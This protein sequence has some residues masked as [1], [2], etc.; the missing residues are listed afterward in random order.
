MTRRLIVVAVVV[1]IA[2]SACGK[3]ALPVSPE[4]RIPRPVTGLTAEVKQG[5]IEV[6]WTNPARRQD[7]TRLLDLVVARVYRNED[8]GT[9]QPKPALLSR[10]RILG[11]PELA[12]VNLVLTP[13]APGAPLPPTGPPPTEPVSWTI[14]GQ[15]VRL[16]DRKDLVYGRR[17]TYVVIVEDYNG[18]V[19]PPSTRASVVYLAAPAPPTGLT[20][21]VGEGQVRV[22]WTAP[23]ALADG[24]PLTAPPLYEVLR[25]T[26]PE[27]PLEVVTPAP[28]PA[29]R[30]IDQNVET[31]RVY[32]YAVRA[33]RRQGET[34]TA[35]EPSARVTAAPVATRAPA[36]PTNV[37]ATVAGTSV[38]LTWTA[39]PTPDLN[40]Y[41]VYRAPAGGAFTRVG[42][43]PATTTVWEDRDV[44]PGTYRYAVA[45]QD[46]T[47]RASESGRSPEVSVTVP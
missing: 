15:S 4:Q 33:L 41:I 37:T 29:T 24:S 10:G 47:A 38:R 3:K 32:T 5:G 9:G 34:L 30:F 40:A 35:G 27:G 42:S 28:L 17:Y 2:A 46:A 36:P 23:T 39:S 7:N 8:D 31:D 44:P 6:V 25:A 20:T 26:S 18:R 16:V 11:Y 14:Q 13:A 43:T 45:A 12:R 1:A 21:E 22:T 19:S